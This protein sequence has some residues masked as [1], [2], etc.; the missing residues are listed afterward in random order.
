MGC[1]EL[2]VSRVEIYRRA[3]IPTFK[4]TQNIPYQISTLYYI[5]DWI[6]H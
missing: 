4:K 1:V 2:M 3:Q 6:V 5:V